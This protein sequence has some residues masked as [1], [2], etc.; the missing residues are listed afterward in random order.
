MSVSRSVYQEGGALQLHGDRSSCPRKPP[1]LV[2]CVSACGC[3]F[4]FYNISCDK[5]VSVSEYFFEFCET[6]QEIIRPGG[7]LLEA[8][9]LYPRWTEVWVPGESLLACMLKGGQCFG[10]E[11]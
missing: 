10:M 4:V 2:L 5:L 6:F 8:L 1:D 11:L 9:T 7:R 3:S